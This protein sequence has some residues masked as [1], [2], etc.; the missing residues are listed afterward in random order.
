MKKPI[1]PES[2]VIFTFKAPPAAA[3]NRLNRAW[4]EEHTLLDDGD[5]K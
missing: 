2:I 4:L 5:R 3:F 1:E